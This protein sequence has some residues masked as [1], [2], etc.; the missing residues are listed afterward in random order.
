ENLCMGYYEEAELIHDILNTNGETT[1]RVLD[2]VASTV[3]VDLLSVHEDMAGRSGALA[4]PTQVIEFIQ[5][6]YR[7]IWDMLKDKGCRLFDQDSDGDMNAVIPAFL[8]AGINVM[9]PMEPASNMDIVKVR[10][11]YG[12]QLAFYGGLNKYL[13]KESKEISRA[14]IQDSFHDQNGRLRPGTRSPGP[15]WNSARELPLLHQ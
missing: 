14:R 13:L 8:E 15:Q 4:G 12:N 2:R 5:P 6:Y 11:T 9:H 10:E 7:R 3:T 1:E